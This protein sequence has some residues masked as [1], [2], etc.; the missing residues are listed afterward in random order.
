MK[1][2]LLLAIL[3]VCADAV[4]AQ[5]DAGM[6]PEFRENQPKEGKPFVQMGTFNGRNYTEFSNWISW[7]VRYPEYAI[8]Q[9]IM[10]IVW[11]NFIVER[12][13]SVSSVRAIN[14]VSEILADEAVSVIERS[15]RWEP[16]IQGV[17]LAD[18]SII[19]QE[20]VR[21]MIQVPVRF[22][23]SGGRYGDGV[24]LDALYPRP[25]T[26]MGPVFNYDEVRHKPTFQG[27]DPSK[28]GEWLRQ[29]VELPKK[30][31]KKGAFKAGVLVTVVPDGSL[32]GVQVLNVSDKNTNAAIKSAA[33]ASP[34][35][36]SGGANPHNLAAVRVLV[37]V[38]FP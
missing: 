25:D 34:K 32:E 29:N 24:D 18:G 26:Y 4:N 17:R 37:V 14:N 27:G 19:E 3:L 30:T 7:H 5:N 33:E 28:F 31:L 16:A 6:P 36:T 13:G 11:V 20:H 23:L 22:E 2:L 38:D 10:G 35:W 1:K 21:V 12:D 15:P 9:G 8:S